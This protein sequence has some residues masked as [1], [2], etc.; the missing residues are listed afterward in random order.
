MTSPVGATDEDDGTDPDDGDRAMT[1]DELSAATGIPSRTIRY[2]QTK[3]VLPHP[4][5]RSRS[6]SY[7]PQHVER[8]R[9]IVELQDRGLRLDAIRDVVRQFEEGG[10]SIQ[11]WL[12][13][14]DRLRTTWADQGP[15]LL[16]RAE[17][18]ERLGQPGHSAISD[19]EHAGLISPAVDHLD[20]YVVTAPALLEINRRLG[21]AGIDLPTALGAERIVR[22]RLSKLADEM[23]E[24]FSERAG[25]GFAASNT[26]ADLAR[27]SDALRDLGVDAVQL[28]FTQEMQRAL[29]EFV[30]RGG[31]VAPEVPKPRHRT[32]RTRR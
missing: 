4:S 23:V 31:G 29:L 15:E 13:L 11:D 27:A 30:E 6:S 16:T 19:L 10:D 28:V 14:G 25:K 24:H 7:G 32:S 1:I 12:G 8:L 2:Y 17:L 5:R 9:L 26:P 20:T 18:L 21:D 3:G 22:R